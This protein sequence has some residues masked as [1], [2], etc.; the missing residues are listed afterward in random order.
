MLEHDW[1]P[2]V[3]SVLY[4]CVLYFCIFPCSAQLSV[5]HMK[6]GC[7]NT[8]NVIIIGMKTLVWKD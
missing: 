6:R 7:R 3:L 4:V 2:D 8:L 1:R 5:F